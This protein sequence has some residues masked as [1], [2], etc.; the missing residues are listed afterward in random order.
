MISASVTGE[1]NF[2]AKLQLLTPAIRAEGKKTVLKLTYDLAREVKK[3]YDTAGLNARS[4]ALKASIQSGGATDSGASV[5]GKVLIGQGLPYA[6]AQE[7][8]ATIVPVNGQYL[9]IPLDAAKTPSGVARFAPRDAVANGY[10]RTFIENGIIF[11]SKWN[12]GHGRND[13][14]PLFKLVRSVT[15]PARPFA[16]PAFARM[17]PTIE[18]EIEAAVKRAIGAVI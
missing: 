6:T 14:V 2:A 18:R 10:D 11:G 17:Q 9:A 3:E 5:T 15:L 1:T 13:F 8:G 7:Y 4:G 12:G 16:R